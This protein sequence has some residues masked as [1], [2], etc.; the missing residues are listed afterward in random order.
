MTK[1]KSFILHSDSLNVLDE[2]S[3][4]QAGA[5]FKA[6]SQYQKDGTCELNG[7]LKA[8]F[9][10]FKNQFDRDDEKYNS[11]CERNKNNGLKGGR[12]KTQITQ[13]VN[14]GLPNNPSEPKEPD[15]KSD[16]KNKNDSE[17]SIIG[18]F[19][20]IWEVWPKLRKGSK[21][22]ALYAY[23]S[24]LKRDTPENINDG[25]QRYIESDEA[26]GQYAKGCAAWFNDDRW[27]NDYSQK[28]GTTN[29][30]QDPKDELRD[31]LATISH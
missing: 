12:P 19:Q 21:S 17:E 2:L 9:V 18:D 14:L 26:K 20:D 5:I 8:I 11:I 1:R 3:D 28:K 31:Y 15:S 13:S 22:K 7:L 30:K 10:S 23:T 25:V 16:N 6:I 29:G 4:E 24:A 27:N